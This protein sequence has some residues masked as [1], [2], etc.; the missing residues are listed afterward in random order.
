MAKLAFQV[1]SNLRNDSR[2]FDP[3][4]DYEGWAISEFKSVGDYGPFADPDNRLWDKLVRVGFERKD[5]GTRY[6]VDGFAKSGENIAFIDTDGPHIQERIPAML[7]VARIFEWVEGEYE[8]GEDDVPK[9][10]DPDDY[11]VVKKGYYSIPFPAG[12][13]LRFFYEDVIR[14]FHVPVPKETA[15][16]LRPRTDIDD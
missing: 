1:R 15:V 16:E 12:L 5:N 3:T 9:G 2:A 4:A 6:L 10:K 14:I 11:W 8:A 13:T 7:E